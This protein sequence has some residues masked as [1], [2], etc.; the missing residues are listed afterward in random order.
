[1][2]FQYTERLIIHA[3]KHKSYHHHYHHH[4]R[5]PNLACAYSTLTVVEAKLI[6]NT[7][8]LAHK[9]TDIIVHVT[10]TGVPNPSSG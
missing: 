7:L 4:H 9:N 2:R 5:M 3:S 6:T 10:I 8:Q 1:M